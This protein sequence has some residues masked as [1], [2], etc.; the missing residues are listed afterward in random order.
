MARALARTS[1]ARPRYVPAGAASH[2]HMAR[3]EGTFGNPIAPP[4]GRRARGWHGGRYPRSDM[5]RTKLVCTIGPATIDRVDELVA[6]GMDMARVNFSHATPT[7]G[8]RPPARPG[9]RRCRGAERWRSSP[10]CPAR[11]SGS[12]TSAGRSVELEAGQPFVLRGRTPMRPGPPTVPASRIPAS[13]RISDGVTASCS[14]TARPSCG[15]RPDRGPEVETEVVRGG[16]IRS[17]AGVSV[18]SERL[19]TPALTERD[20]ADLPTAIEIGADYVAQSFV[21]RASD[22]HELRELL[23]PTARRSSRRS[24]RARRSTTSMRSAMRPGR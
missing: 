20:R 1:P 5:P 16:R 4:G 18:P 8:R 6:A 24:R 3:R 7:T 13:P 19:S 2:G 10:T 17:R 22:V 21:R 12:A 14:P 23:G 9:G 15:S 11:R